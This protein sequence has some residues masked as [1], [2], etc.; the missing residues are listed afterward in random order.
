MPSGRLRKYNSPEEMQPL[1]DAYF[2]SCDKK[3]E[4]INTDKGIK[5]IYEPYTVSG[6]CLAL[7]MSRET[8]LQYEKLE[9]FSDTIKRAKKRI[10]NWIESKALNG[11]INPTVSIFNLKNNFGWTDKTETEISNKKGESF[12]Q[13]VTHK[14]DNELNARILELASKE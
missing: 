2:E 12:K 5:V 10:E 9:T 11:Q 1:I 6:L 14:T 3:K 13:E 7:D 4:V 8:L